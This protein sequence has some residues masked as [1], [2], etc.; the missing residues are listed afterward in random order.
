MSAEPAWRREATPGLDIQPGRH[1]LAIVR[2]DRES[3]RAAEDAARMARMSGCA[4]IVALVLEPPW[5]LAFDPSGSAFVA[6]EDSEIDVAIEL[7]RMLDPYG[8]PWR[9]WPIKAD[10]VTTIAGLIERGP[11]RCVVVVRRRP[12]HRIARI[13]RAIDRRFDLPVLSVE[14]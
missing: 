10:P 3:L 12:W 11:V 4:L 8:V 5:L 13:A 9:L 14:T 7:T 6:M 1:L 2:C